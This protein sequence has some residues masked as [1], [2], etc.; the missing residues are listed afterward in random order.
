MCG[1]SVKP[2]RRGRASHPEAH[3]REDREDLGRGMGKGGARDRVAEVGAAPR[4][5]GP[6]PSVGRG[7]DVP[8]LCHNRRM[9]ED[10]ERLC[11][12]SEAFVYATMVRL[13]V[14]RLARA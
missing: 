5:R 6:A 1:S 4:L 13:M 7:A 3:T 9:S 12:T 8:W 2:E 14:R 10:Y 11:A